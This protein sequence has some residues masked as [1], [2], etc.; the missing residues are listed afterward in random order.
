MIW[1]IVII[2][3]G[4]IVYALYNK[5]NFNDISQHKVEGTWS[6][7]ENK[8]IVNPTDASRT[9]NF[10]T[11]FK[12]RK[13]QIANEI[14]KLSGRNMA[15]LSDK[16][17]RE[18][19]SSIER[20]SS[21]AGKPISQLKDGF[22]NELNPVI[23][24]LGLDAMIERM[25]QEREKEAKTFNIS[26]DNTISA[27][28]LE[29]LI[30]RKTKKEQQIM[31][32]HLNQVLADK[33]INISEEQIQQTVDEL[34]LAPDISKLDREENRLFALAN[35][36]VKM[37]DNLT[38]ELRGEPKRLGENGEIEARILCSTLV[39]D[40]HSHFKNEIDLDIQVDRYFLLLADEILGS[41]IDD[42]IEFLNS[43]ISFYQ[44]NIKAF[45]GMN[46]LELFSIDNALGILYNALYIHPLSD[47]PEMISREEI[48]SNELV[49]FRA[50]LKKVI[51]FLQNG[52]NRITGKSSPE[53]ET[54][55]ASALDALNSVIPS[56]KRGQMNKDVAWLFSDQIIF[57]I[58]NG[59]IDEKLPLP[60]EVRQNLNKLIL[61][62]KNSSMTSSKIGEILDDAQQ[63]FI[64]S[65][66]D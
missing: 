17:A 6:N 52:R 39:I 40:L 18:I 1:V 64:N 65:F 22:F 57:M 53:E 23:D 14:E 35:E 24:E 28:L 37:L 48:S 60:Y 30:E 19:V 27:I 51:K 12:R 55:R 2:I 45:E 10:W 20:W 58:K 32:N 25:K 54:F 3:V 46:E 41:D 16:D 36:G 34:N 66:S 29:L 15:K 42:P 63:E 7:Q 44:N 59:S 9:S 26:L 13:P 56:N 50:K 49:L 4:V 61:T 8:G 47:N 31:Q 62:I 5:S 11:N 38:V 43:R 21:N 33:G